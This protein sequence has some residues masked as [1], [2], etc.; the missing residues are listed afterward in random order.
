VLQVRA[1][2]VSSDR[3][4]ASASTLTRVPIEYTTSLEG[5]EPEHLQGFFEGWPSPPSPEGHLAVLKESYRVALAREAGSPQVIGFAN[6][7]S[8]GHLSAFIPLLEVLPRHRG[9]G[10]GTEL[11]RRLLAELDGLYS[12]DVVC[13]E[14]LRPFYARFG[15]QPLPAMALRRR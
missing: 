8:D 3:P 6:A 14:E 11:V 13:D 2:C 10:I 4:P 12:I 9:Q 5:V 15:M 1:E 7:L